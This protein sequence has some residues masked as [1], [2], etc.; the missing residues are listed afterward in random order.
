VIIRSAFGR[1]GWRG[2]LDLSPIP[3]PMPGHLS[4]QLMQTFPSF[5]ALIARGD[6]LGYYDL[7]T[8]STVDLHPA[9]RP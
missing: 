4:A 8:S 5:L 9:A 2:G 6:S 7:L 1:G 3:Q